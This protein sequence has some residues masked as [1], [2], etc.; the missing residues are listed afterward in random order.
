LGGLN[1]VINWDDK[2]GACYVLFSKLTKESNLDSSRWITESERYLDGVSSASNG[3]KFTKGGLYFCDGDSN[4]ASLNPA[5]NAAF[6]SLLYSP[7]ATSIDKS[8]NYINFANSQINYLLGKNPLKIPYVIGVHPNS[9]QNPHHAGAHGG[10]DIGNL[11][12]PPVTQYILYGS[13]VGGPTQKDSFNDDRNNY[14]ETEV[15]L[16][17]NAPFQSLM[18]YQVINSKEDPYYVTLPPGRGEIKE[19]NITLI[20]A[21]VVIV[22]VILFVAGMIFWK[23][24]LISKQWKK[25]KQKYNNN[26]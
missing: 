10:T 1:K 13:I 4:A 23:R 12:N 9:P 18:A 6:V 26:G 5:L 2:T 7:L 11:N 17:Y 25:L 15:A 3:C 21:V 19:T 22:F 16:D 14:E 20:I 24:K 8:N